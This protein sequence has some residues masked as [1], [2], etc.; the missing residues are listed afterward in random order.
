MFTWIKREGCN[1]CPI[2]EGSEHYSLNLGRLY[3]GEV[4]FNGK[5]W[6]A[7]LFIADSQHVATGQSGGTAT[8]DD[9]M[10]LIEND[11]LECLSS[12]MSA[13]R[14]PTR[15]IYEALVRFDDQDNILRTEVP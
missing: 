6:S 3:R 11:I 10:K 15:K 4:K 14:D 5:T 1:C 13:L 8:R 2:P 7:E 9:C 12:M